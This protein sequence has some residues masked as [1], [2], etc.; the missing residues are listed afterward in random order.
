MMLPAFSLRRAALT[1]ALVLA[2]LPACTGEDDTKPTTATAGETLTP[3]PGGAPTDAADGR[4]TCVGKNAPAPP[5]GTSLELTGYVR[6]LA[7]PGAAAGAPPAA[8]VEVFTKSGTSLGSSFSDPAKAGRTSVT[9]PITSEGFTGYADV[10]LAGYLAYRFRTSRAVTDTAFSAWAWLT[11]QAEAT[12]RAT[13]LGITL[14][15]GTGILVG[16]VHDCDGFGVANVVIQVAGK[17]DGVYYVE[18]F[19]LAKSRTYTTDTG[20]FVVPNLPTGTVTVKA[21]G[22]LRT[23]QPLELLSSITAEVTADAIAAVH[24][25]PR[26]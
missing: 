11:T 16:A 21:F 17:T 15:S 5:E 25:A 12:Q 3:E 22:R 26:G 1:A 6:M 8:G 14:Q 4:L 23:G 19:D 24:L 2:A 18:G 10:T 7:D 9:V 13:T 20:R